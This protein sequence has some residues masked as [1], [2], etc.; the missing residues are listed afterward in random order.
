MRNSVARLARS[1]VASPLAGPL[2]R[3]TQSYQAKYETPFAVLGIRTIG[4]RVTDIDYLEKGVAT[5]APLNRLAIDHLA[6]TPDLAPVRI[7]ALSNLSPQGRPISDHFG[8]VVQLGRTG[9]ACC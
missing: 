7:R 2:L 1:G 4:D 6:H 5:L 9:T 3:P 8:V